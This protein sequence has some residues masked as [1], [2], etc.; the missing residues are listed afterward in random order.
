MLG[1]RHTTAFDFY[2]CVIISLPPLEEWGE[3]VEK[4]VLT[5]LG[6]RQMVDRH[7]ETEFAQ[8]E[9]SVELFRK[10]LGMDIPM[11]GFLRD[12]Q[13]YK[14]LER[15]ASAVTGM[16]IFSRKAFG[17]ANGENIRDVYER[18]KE[19]FEISEVPGLAVFD[20]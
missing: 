9:E 17:Q 4:H 5:K 14:E 12:E 10:N 2:V 20:I 18:F 16:W 15:N 8:C 6:M 1:V 19:H 7:R 13:S 11:R 3:E